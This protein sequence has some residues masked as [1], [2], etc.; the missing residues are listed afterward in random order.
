M[1]IERWIYPAATTVRQFDAQRGRSI[2]MLKREWMISVASLFF[3]T[4]S[5]RLFWQY[6]D[7]IVRIHV[8]IENYQ[9]ANTVVANDPPH[10]Y[11]NDS[12]SINHA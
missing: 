1:A 11:R 9:I 3:S 4:V 10:H 2:V 5:R 12:T 8:F 6:S 7:I